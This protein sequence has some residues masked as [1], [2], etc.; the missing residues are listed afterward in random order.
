MPLPMQRQ[1]RP[2]TASRAEEEGRLWSEAR[3]R[4]ESVQRDVAGLLGRQVAL[5]QGSPPGD[6]GPASWGTSRGG[7]RGNPVAEHVDE[8]LRQLRAQVEGQLNRAVCVLRNQATSLR[9]AT[10]YAPQAVPPATLGEEL[11]VHQA[12]AAQL[13]DLRES[14]RVSEE[15]RLSATLDQARALDS[16]HAEAAQAREY[17]L[18]RDRQLLVLEQQALDHQQGA[19]Q[20]IAGLE[21]LLKQKQQALDRA[22]DEHAELTAVKA[23]LHRAQ[24]E[25]DL[26]SQT[27]EDL[28]KQNERLRAQLGVPAQSSSDSVD[29]WLSMQETAPLRDEI[30][31]LKTELADT[32]ERFEKVE[33]A[34]KRR[35]LKNKNTIMVLTREKAD[36]ETAHAVALESLQSK[37]E[38]CITQ[39]SHSQDQIH[40]LTQEA[41]SL[42]QQNAALQ[43]Q[44]P[45]ASY[46]RSNSPISPPP[47]PATAPPLPQALPAST[48]GN[49]SDQRIAMSTPDGTMAQ[50]SRP[51]LKRVGFESEG[52]L[53]ESNVRGPLTGAGIDF[54]SPTTLG[55]LDEDT[56]LSE[57]SRVEE[58]NARI[59]AALNGLDGMP[60]AEAR[61]LAGQRPQSAHLSKS[62]TSK[63]RSSSTHQKEPQRPHP[64]LGLEVADSVNVKSELGGK[65]S[66]NGIIVVKVWGPAEA[67]G[68]RK[69][70]VIVSFGGKS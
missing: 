3:Q 50:L 6:D 10:R 69:L 67:A 4:A 48:P 1:P 65:L 35:D 5:H 15:I 60:A 58:E 27:C 20:Q 56:I 9:L 41:S 14:L 13:A 8:L 62:L 33:T 46:K 29:A 59:R 7:R 30:S 52:R 39:L 53:D 37:L 70:D 54:T 31:A 34:K 25:A 63:K 24:G 44:V 45:S 49:L 28:R 12:H 57:I 18:A 43:S 19:A 2:A 61:A 40:C 36:A 51:P 64:M 42:A 21:D 17:V 47:E 22:Q 55:A 66:Y 23:A 38:Q 68:S 16:A 11:Q 32:K 26:Q